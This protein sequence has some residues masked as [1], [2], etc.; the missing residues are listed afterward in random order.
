[1]QPMVLEDLPTF[2]QTKSPS[3]VGKYII[4]RAYGIYIYIFILCPQTNENLSRKQRCFFRTKAGDAWGFMVQM[5]Q[6][7]C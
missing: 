3:Y 6:I 5:T 2:A 7:T 4:H 1:M